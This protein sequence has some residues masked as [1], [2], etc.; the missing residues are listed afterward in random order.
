[1]GI[2]KFFSTVNRTFD[3]IST[4][5]LDNSDGSEMN[6]FLNNSKYL[7]LDFNSII[8]HTSSKLIEELNQTRSKNPD[9]KSL[10]INDIEW[11]IIREVNN[12]LIS[13]L[14]KINL[15]KLNLVYVALDGVPT[16]SK[17]IEQ[18][19]RRFVGDF[20]EKLLENYSLPFS[21]SKNNISPG[22]VFMEKIHQYL[23]N[24]KSITKNKLVK[25]ED[26]ILKPKDYEFYSKIK[27]FD[28]SDTNIEG[29]G[30]M[31]IYDLISSLPK[32]EN[33]LFYSPDADVILLSMISKNSNNI[34]VLK[35]DNMTS[36][37]N[38]I[39]IKLLKETIYNYC[40]DR[41][42]GSVL[43]S[44]QLNKL[45]R[46]LVFVFTMFGNDFLPRCESI[47]TNQDFLFLIDMYLIN[48]INYGHLVLE[49]E[50]SNIAFFNYLQLLEAHETRL[51]FRNAYQNVHQ[52]YNY[53][54]QKNFYMDL[55]A[56]KKLN[57]SSDKTQLISRKFADPFYNF[58]NNLLHYIDPAKIKELIEKYKEPKTKKFHGCLEFYLY[59]R[60]KVYQIIHDAL[61]T[62]LPINSLFTFDLSNFD[63][64]DN[65]YE[66]LKTTQFQSKIKKHLMNMRELGPRERELYLI[67]NKLDKYYSLFNPTN[68]FFQSILS[69]R[70]INTLYYYQKYFKNE[71]RKHAVNAY[72]KGF[73]WVFQYYFN[74]PNGSKPQLNIDETWY[75][76]YFKAPLF[77]SI[78]RFYSPTLIDTNFKPVH[79][80]ITPLEQL[81]YITPVRLSDL[82]NPDF[83]KLFAEFKSGKFVDEPFVKKIKG[84]IEKHPQYFYNLDEIYNGIKTG[85]IKKNIFD[86][87]NSAFISKCHYHIL[88]Y[89]V[90]ITQ[91]SNKLRTIE[92]TAPIKRPRS[93]T[94]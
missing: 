12:F 25:K 48:L 19:K 10:G 38:L 26:L 76:P 45:I 90:S 31:K 75:Y 53:A 23:G 68:E 59:D 60:N 33:I 55:M 39:D 81:L 4:I 58:Y 50:I 44:I 20:V 51:L 64:T 6:I 42:T 3:I 67:N 93:K 1:M 78:V 66:K 77:E 79:L 5:D 2:E 84:F 91:F 21:W 7:L 70:K 74:R 13:I 72:L 22:T 11:M 56:F 8:H 35:F 27:H 54:N 85:S 17:I 82:S 32:N 88:D 24:I 30:E 87:S 61:D 43:D 65:N 40:L 71:D 34:Q 92:D 18:K 15:E 86:C 62:T 63:T 46:D 47:Q 57:L 80:N 52:N 83:Y 94:F 16:F 9:Y 69:T 14:E 29:E 36:Q 28:Y 89:V 49:N 73:K 41:I 37:L